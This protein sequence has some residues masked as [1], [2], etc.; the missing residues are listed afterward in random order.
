MARMK[1]R[2]LAEQTMKP[3]SIARAS[4]AATREIAAMEL[5]ALRDTLKVTQTDLADRMKVSQAAI[6]KLEKPNRNIHVDQLRSIVSA[7][8]GNLRII[9]DFADRTIEL[10]HIG[11]ACDSSVKKARRH[12][13]P[14]AAAR[15]LRS[16]SR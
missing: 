8:G 1:F 12:K 3:D 14:P 6:S 16:E 7:M 2:E 5:A 10:S 15:A 9:A 11:K 4:K 13:A